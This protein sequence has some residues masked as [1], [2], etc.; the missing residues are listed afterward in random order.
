M[1]AESTPDRLLRPLRQ[2]LTRPQW[3]NLLALVVA[4]QVGR[5]LVL[6]QLALFFVTAIDS[7]SCYRRLERILAYEQERTWK[8]LSQLWVRAVLR[9]FAPG[10]GRLVLLIDWTSHRDQCK[11]LWVML[12]LGGRA[13]PLCFWL[14]APETGGPGSQRQL[15]DTALRELKQWLPR[16]RVVLVGDRGFRGAD[17]IR[18]LRELGW[19]FVLRIT[20]ETKIQRGREWRALGEVPPALG[21]RWQQAGVRLG[22]HD[23]V[24]VNVVAVQ[25]RL[26]EPKVEKD[27]Q[28]KPTGRLLW[29]TLWFLATDLP[30]HEDAV[31]VYGWRMQIEETFRDYKSLL[32]LEEARVKQPWD[33]LHALLWAVMIGLTLDLQRSPDRLQHPQ[34]LPRISPWVT[35]APVRERPEYRSESATRQGLHQFFVE[36]VQGV[37]PFAAD[38]AAMVEKSRRMQARPQVQARRKTGPALR[39]RG[40]NPS[41]A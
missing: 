15:E 29:T 36:L 8:P 12:P 26:R 24:E 22:K 23:P 7:A 2:H 11:S 34:R 16:R 17:R 28:G 38:L 32:R 5:T 41:P 18:L 25:Q 6:R 1:H 19:Q 35:Q 3:Q 10:R 33:R 31:A 37:L 40:R 13:V 30:L 39:H 14:A 27:A 9:C 4:V 20:A 21:R